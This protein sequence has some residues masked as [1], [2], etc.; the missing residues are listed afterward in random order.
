MK[1]NPEKFQFFILSKNRHPEYNLLIYS[2]IIKESA[3]VEM[4]GLI[5][6]NKPSFQKQITKLC[7]TASYKPHALRWIKK[8]L[9]LEKAR[10][11]GNAFVVSQVNCVLQKNYTLQ[12]AEHLP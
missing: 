4:L 2:N 11:F 8:Y 6:D 12:N 1:A 9:T 5:A 10:V 3:D 7:W